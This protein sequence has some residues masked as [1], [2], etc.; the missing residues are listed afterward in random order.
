MN[1]SATSA[2]TSRGRWLVLAAALL[3][4]TSGLFVKSPPLARIPE[5]DRG[6]LLACYRALFAA[7]FLIPAV[8]PA[9]VRFRPMLVPMTAAFTAM[10]LLIV[11]AL[12]RTTAAAAIF[13]QYTSAAWAFLFGV[14]WLREP[15]ERGNL[16]ALLV[17]VCGIVWIVVGDRSGG[18]VVGN[19]LA[20]TSGVAYA[21]VIICLRHLR[22]ESTAWLVALN[23]IIAGLV[24]LP[25]AISLNVQLDV[26]QWLLAA[27][28]GIVQMGL[29]YYLFARGVR[30]LS[31]QEAALIALTEPI[32]NPVWV[33]LV[34]REPVSA[35]TWIGG[36]FIVGGLAIR[37]LR[38]PNPRDD[39]EQ[40]GERQ[41]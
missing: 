38:F 36:A 26:T 23:H 22:N 3:W 6:P 33:A 39:D 24:L 31:A 30:Y 18:N 27:G 15:V 2:E 34:W 37:Y 41:A 17:A 40:N 19:L 4:S 21:A 5:M 12:T 25:W 1:Q 14:L 11:T 20:L 16:V 13:L 8:R 10:N 9:A 29:P 7:L 35:T 32:F 28:F